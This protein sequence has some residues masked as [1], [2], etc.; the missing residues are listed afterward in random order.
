MRQAEL[1]EPAPGACT[2]P[3]SDLCAGILA[4][5]QRGLPAPPLPTHRTP[6]TPSPCLLALPPAPAGQVRYKARARSNQD[7][8]GEG[9]SPP[10]SLGGRLCAPARGVPLPP[11]PAWLH[12]RRPLGVSWA[13]SRTVN[14]AA[15]YSTCLE[16]LMW[17]TP[18]FCSAALPPASLAGCTCAWQR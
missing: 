2:C 6:V 18:S 15:A 1:P 16:A 5:S 11:C 13:S 9:G 14:A 12:G 8:A 4:G 10:V 17:R 3:A 7:E